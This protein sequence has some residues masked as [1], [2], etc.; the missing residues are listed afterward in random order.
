M[1]VVLGGSIEG[2]VT[3]ELES[4]IKES[5][6]HLF[7]SGKKFKTKTKYVGESCNTQ[8]IIFLFLTLKI[9]LLIYLFIIMC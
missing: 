6:L 1:K 9:Q 3:W 8:K 4:Q 7:S 2:S 5:Y